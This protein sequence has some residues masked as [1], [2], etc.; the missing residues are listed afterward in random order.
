MT[1]WFS[2]KRV[3]NLQDEIN[4]VFTDFG[5]TPPPGFGGLTSQPRTEIAKTKTGYE[6]EI[7]F[8]F[9]VGPEQIEAEVRDG[10]LVITVDRPAPE[11][12]G[13]KVDIRT[14]GS[15][16]AQAEGGTGE[17]V[18]SSTGATEGPGGMMG[19]GGSSNPSGAPRGEGMMGEGV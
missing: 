6:V 18:R 4:R 3:G 16:G 11:A 1:D 7:A 2:G 17:G 9:T 12:S 19:E 13:A 5:F 8:P 14:G 15:S 10:K